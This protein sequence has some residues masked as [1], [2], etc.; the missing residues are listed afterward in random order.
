M[1]SIGFFLKKEPIPIR[2]SQKIY[3]W[4]ILS[5]DNTSQI[6]G[7]PY[8]EKN[9]RFI[10]GNGGHHGFWH[11]IGDVFLHLSAPIVLIPL[12]IRV[13]PIQIY[14]QKS[15]IVGIILYSFLLTYLGFFLL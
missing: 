2:F 4:S 12:R 8:G 5:Q 9:S 14:L 11:F 6:K 7:N 15:I 10:N 1:S 3:K 13:E